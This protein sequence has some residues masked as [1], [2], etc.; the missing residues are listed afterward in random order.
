MVTFYST[1]RAEMILLPFSYI[2]E[3]NII[4]Q[5]SRHNFVNQYF[6]QFSFSSPPISVDE[7]P[8]ESSILPNGSAG[9]YH[10]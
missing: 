6:I 2:K 5:A 1:H 3:Q 9:L 7:V 8:S 10:F 4:Q